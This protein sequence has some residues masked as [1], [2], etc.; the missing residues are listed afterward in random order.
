MLFL[1]MVLIAAF[2]ATR[3]GRSQGNP[4]RME[5]NFICYWNRAPLSPPLPKNEAAS[6]A[7]GGTARIL[8]RSIRPVASAEPILS[9]SP[10]HRFWPD[11]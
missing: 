6:I 4:A 11:S 3:G 5:P 9:R 1:S 2:S 10:E 7:R 8:G